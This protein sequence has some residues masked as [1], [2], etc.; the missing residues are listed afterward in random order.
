MEKDTVIQK[1]QKLLKLQYNAE[2]IGSTGEAYQAAKMVRKLLLEYNL[3][4]KDIQNNEVGETMTVKESDP[5]SYADQYGMTWK[6]NLMLVICEN[7]LCKLV[8]VN[9]LKRM[10]IVGTEANVIICKEFYQY[11][12]QVFRRLSMERLNEAQNEYLGTGMFMTE[13]KKKDFIRSYLEGVS[14]GL[15]EN[16]GSQRPTSEETGLVLSHSRLIEDYFHQKNIVNARSRRTRTEVRADGYDAGYDDGR[17]VSLN[18]Q[19]KNK[20]GNLNFLEYNE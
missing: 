4:L 8:T 1:I 10:R 2:K 19:I 18:R 3:S 20:E 11:L 17:N 6:R 7:N 16:Y 12:L 13:A 15:Q 9:Q 14:R 5:F